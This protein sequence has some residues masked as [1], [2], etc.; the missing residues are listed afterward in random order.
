MPQRPALLA[1]SPLQRSSGAA[2]PSCRWPL[3]AEAACALSLFHARTIA[4][5]FRSRRHG[6]KSPRPVHLAAST[7][8]LPRWPPIR[9]RSSQ[10]KTQS[11]SPRN[12][13]PGGERWAAQLYVI[14]LVAVCLEELIK[15]CQ[16]EH[17]LSAAGKRDG[18]ELPLNL[19]GTKA[20]LAID[21]F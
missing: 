7:I 3:A 13:S 17:F 20:P 15:A 8:Y 5:E 18:P 10:K 9:C 21:A 19:G 2:A 4:V 1:A 6:R 14:E 12:T 11:A 16:I